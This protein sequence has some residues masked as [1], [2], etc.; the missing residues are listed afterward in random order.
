MESGI[1]KARREIN[2]GKIMFKKLIT[3]SILV[4]LITWILQ[5]FSE[6]HA[7]KRYYYDSEGNKISEQE[8]QKII[9]PEGKQNEKPPQKGE[10]PVVDDP[11]AERTTLDD[12]KQS[13]QAA[14]EEEDDDDVDAEGVDVKYMAEVSSETI[15]RAFERDTVET[16]HGE[17]KDNS[18]ALPAY[19]YL[20][21]D[22]GALDQSG[23][24]VHINGWGRYDFNDSGFYEDNPDGELLYGYLEYSRPDYGLNLT[25]GR[26]HVMA[27][28]INNSLDGIGI[29]IA[30]TSY[31][32]FSAYGG[33]PV[34]LSSEDGRSG[35]SIWG[36]R[37]AGHR[38][39]DY[40]IGLSYKKK[41]S[42]GGDD[43]E[44]GGIDLFAELPLNINFFGFSSY[45]LDT[46]G[47]GEHSYDVRFEISDFHFRPFYER[48]RYEDFFNTKDN[49][50]NPFR[51]LADTEEV[52]SVI[53]SDV[54]WRRFARVDLGAIVNFYDYD[55]RDD[56]A[57]YVEGNANWNLNGL[58]RIGGK[59]GR[60]HGDT[61]E[62][63]YL[64]TRGFFYWNNPY[65]PVRLGFITGD[66][67]YV[68]YDEE[69]FGEDYSF[70]VSL[71]GGWR[72]FDDALEVKLSG[73]WSHDP[74]FDSDLRGLLKIQY[75]Y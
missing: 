51:F 5:D 46:D 6:L 36:G 7:G 15:F 18:P 31:F 75:T 57:L 72:F 32:K 33:S 40:E 1:F 44:V 35:D 28:V 22:F 61:S 64:L 60:M 48:Y 4:L 53:G 62:T 20:R 54:I 42:D 14:A 68:H 12:E 2:K 67:I 37:V 71:G 65:D 11:P 39:A 58:T 25:L 13:V 74:F 69:I 8:Y 43:E 70:W 3:G 45:N 50:A 47:F 10:P 49:S 16:L 56:S 63:R 38:G 73:D 17:K 34:G 55:K 27:G 29:K 30:L 59:F 52:L 9:D 26:R 24:S 19:Q 66:V 21:L 41:R 23:V